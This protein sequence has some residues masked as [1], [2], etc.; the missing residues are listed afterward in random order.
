MNH[1][2]PPAM[3]LAL[4]ALSA[5]A[6]LH[7]GS[8]D[9][10][11]MTDPEVRLLVGRS[12]DSLRQLT[13]DLAVPVADGSAAIDTSFPVSLIEDA[14]TGVITAGAAQLERP[15]LAAKAALATL[16]LLLSYCREQMRAADG[17]EPGSAAARKA[18]QVISQRCTAPLALMLG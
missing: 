7:S 13:G 15:G 3:A 1:F 2:Y 10:N 11:G 6:T 4:L 8:A 17:L 16:T 18:A 9:G 14:R 12:V 5:C